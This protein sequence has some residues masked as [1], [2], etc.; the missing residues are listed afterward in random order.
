MKKVQKKISLKIIIILGILAFFLLFFLSLFCETKALP[1]IDGINAFF[2]R[3]P[4]SEGFNS[5]K[6]I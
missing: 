4:S 2:R 5:A 3:N 6:T 1:F